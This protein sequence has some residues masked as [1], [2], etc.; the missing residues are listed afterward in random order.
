MFIFDDRLFKKKVKAIQE[1]NP[2]L[3][4]NHQRKI[5]EVIKNWEKSTL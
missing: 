3:V 2:K 1:K 5:K 4:R